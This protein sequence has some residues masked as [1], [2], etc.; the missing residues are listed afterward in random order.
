MG[1]GEG[2][3]QSTCGRVAQHVRGALPRRE[4]KRAVEGGR[5]PSA[6]RAVSSSNR[7]NRTRSQQHEL[8]WTGIMISTECGG[9]LWFQANLSPPRFAADKIPAGDSV[10][11]VRSIEVVPRDARGQG[12]TLSITPTLCEW[13]GGLNHR[14]GKG[15]QES[16]GHP[17]EGPK[18]G[19]ELPPM[20]PWSKTSFACSWLN[21]R[22]G[23]RL[24]PDFS[25]LPLIGCRLDCMLHCR[26]ER[27]WATRA[28]RAGDTREDRQ[29]GPLR[30]SAAFSCGKRL[31]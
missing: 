3:I 1:H 31:L 26:P 18:R 14:E 20:I 30:R 9:M 24:G 17:R 25:W 19:Q 21:P 5:L 10:N 29:L 8:S 13:R 22:A 11:G 6:G 7:G 12:G 28:G 15:K 23:P 16:K 27:A 2:Y 4:G